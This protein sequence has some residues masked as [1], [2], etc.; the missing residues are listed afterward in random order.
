MFSEIR[1]QTHWR[2]CQHAACGHMFPVKQASCSFL[3]VTFHCFLFPF[4][5][6]FLFSIFSSCHVILCLLS[7]LLLILL[8]LLIFIFTLI[9]PVLPI[10]N[11]SNRPPAFLFVSFFFSYSYIFYIHLL[12]FNNNQLHVPTYEICKRKKKTLLVLQHCINSG[13][14][15]FVFRL[16]VASQ[17]LGSLMTAPSWT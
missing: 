15:L 13:L 1:I 5:F 17:G 3:I 16:N 6:S 9:L 10:F 14:R 8:W 4:F 12:F 11:S 7:N 2:T